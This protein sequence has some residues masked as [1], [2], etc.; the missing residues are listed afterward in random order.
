LIPFGDEYEYEYDFDEDIEEEEEV[1]E[2]SIES[3][4]ES[5]PLI[6]SGAKNVFN[7]EHI[8]KAL[9]DMKLTPGDVSL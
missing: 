9:G 2:I 4:D 7:I 5:N 3:F 8:M 1:D 6:V